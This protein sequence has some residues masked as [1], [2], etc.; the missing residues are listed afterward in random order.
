MLSK[1][2]VKSVQRGTYESTGSAYNDTEDIQIAQVNAEKCL[3]ALD[4][5]TAA[6]SSSFV[7]Y[8][9]ATLSNDKITVTFRSLGVDY[10]A[11]WQ[12][13]EFY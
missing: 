10:L 1:G 6:R 13:I 9:S 7:G 2:T 4:V 8:N 12:V 3:L 11:Q 5:F